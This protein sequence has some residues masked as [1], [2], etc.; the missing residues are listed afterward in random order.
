MLRQHDLIDV[1]WFQSIEGFT[2]GL[3]LYLCDELHKRDT[4]QFGGPLDETG[5]KRAMFDGRSTLTDAVEAR[6]QR[7]ADK[8]NAEIRDDCWHATGEA[9]RFPCPGAGT[10]QA[11]SRG[12]G[13][14]PCEG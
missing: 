2:E 10:G 4:W 11:R 7:A 14:G 5:L 3:L 9:W 13:Q 8:L 6:D 12:K 1:T